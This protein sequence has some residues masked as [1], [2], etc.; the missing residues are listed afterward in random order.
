M[1]CW[2]FWATYNIRFAIRIH[3]RDS[4]L[5]LLI[6]RLFFSFLFRPIHCCQ[7]GH[8]T[9]QAY[10]IL[11]ICVFAR[12]SF[13]HV[14]LMFVG[15]IVAG[16]QC[17]VCEIFET[18]IRVYVYTSISL[19]LAHII[20]PYR[21]WLLNNQMRISVRNLI[22]ETT[23]AANQATETKEVACVYICVSMCAEQLIHD[24]YTTLK[25]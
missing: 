14:S 23:A 3:A 16:V 21:E 19:C 6:L 13:L 18:H 17:Q 9:H 7:N 22:W 20:I 24:R 11:C 4:Q 5:L 2:S 25:V 8:K 12:F 15:V 10:C 1:W